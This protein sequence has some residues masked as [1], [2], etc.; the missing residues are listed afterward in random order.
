MNVAVTGSGGY[1]AEYLLR[2][3]E[4]E[5][6][7]DSVLKLGRTE[8]ADE[9]LDLKEAERFRYDSLNKIDFIIFTAA[10][11]G[12]DRCAAEFDECWSVNV[13][14]TIFFIEE[15]LKRGCRVLFFSSDAVFG[16]IPGKVYTELSETNAA[17]P[18]GRMKKAVE[19]RFMDEPLFKTVRLSY[20]VSRNDRFV[21]YCLD[22]IS[23]EETAE[24]FHPFY[25][26]CITISDVSDIVMWLIKHWEEYQEPALNAAGRELVSRVRIADELNRHL[27][28]R[29]KYTVSYPGDEFY[30]NRPGIIQM[31]SLYIGKYHI[32]EE[33]SFT[34]KI[35]KE[36]EVI[37]YEY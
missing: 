1:I 29:L 28:G 14:G 24:V 5:K 18:Y 22:C 11:S 15:A 32:L 25:R 10:V 31:E 19:D 21:S 13:K 2:R 12:P 27:G 16:D 8:Q 30:Q 23:K 36:L 17:A 37:G 7:I 3:F 20:V 9:Y 26:N 35:K 33:T 4:K 6:C 34:E